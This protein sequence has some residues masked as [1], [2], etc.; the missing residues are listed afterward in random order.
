MVGFIEA[1][2]AA[3]EDG[4]IEKSRDIGFTWVAGGLAINKWLFVPG[5]KTTFGSRKEEY[6]D[7]IGDPDSIFEKIRMLLYALPAWMLPEGFHRR[8]HDKFMLLLNPANGN[9]ITGEAGDQMGRG[10]RS[11]LYFIDEA[12]FIERAQR[13]EASTS[14]NT[15]V[16]IW[17]STVN[18]PAGLFA[19]KRHGGSLRPEQIFTFHWRDDPRKDEKWEQDTRRKLEPHVF[20]SEYDIDYSASV[21][22]I[23]IPAKW[24]NAAKRIAGLMAARGTP[25]EPDVSGIGGLDVGAGGKGKSVFVARFGPVVTVAKS[26]GD[27]DTIE[28]AHRGLDEAQAEQP[29]RSDGWQPRVKTLR[30]DAPGVGVGVASALMHHAREGII[31]VGVNTGMPPTTTQWP[32][33][34]TS[35]EKFG[36]LKA[37]AMWLMRERFKCTHE[38]VLFLEDPNHKGAHEHP[39]SDLISIPDESAGPDAAA[40][41]AQISLLKSFRNEKGKIVIE[42][43]QQL[44]T[45]GI[46]SPDHLDALVLTFAGTDNI[47]L[48]EKLAG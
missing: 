39:V 44:A 2:V 24:V 10:G 38:M 47:S 3:S 7:G 17:G 34:G 19:T 8:Q 45:R 1:R 48:W 12:A 33:G 11:T 29:V 25:I 40:L 27:P 16:R 28:T 4:L 5:F 20:A 37:E 14:A 30:F 46:A 21:E 31:T 35:V 41:A 42:S 23:C 32:D 9:T 6:V 22:G 26:W 18:G 15:D 43:K 36:N 13:V